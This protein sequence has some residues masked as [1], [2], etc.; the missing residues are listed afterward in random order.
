[1]PGIGPIVQGERF[2]NRVEARYGGGSSIE[3]TQTQT[4][5]RDARRGPHATRRAVDVYTRRVEHEFAVVVADL[6][7]VRQYIGELEPAGA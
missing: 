5:T 1:M 7:V 4:I 6:A 3:K 2:E